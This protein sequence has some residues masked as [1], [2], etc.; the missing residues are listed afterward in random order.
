MGKR[1]TF[2]G[3][4]FVGASKRHAHVRMSYPLSERIAR[5]QAMRS[6]A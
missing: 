6:L 2:N 4:R 1:G 5:H 3:S